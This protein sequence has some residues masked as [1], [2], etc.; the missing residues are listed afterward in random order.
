MLDCSPVSAGSSPRLV[1]VVG[2]GLAERLE[3][4]KFAAPGI[5][6]FPTNNQKL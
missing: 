5:I 6:P 2:R 3:V 4:R 1:V